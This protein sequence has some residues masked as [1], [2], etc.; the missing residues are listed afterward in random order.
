MMKH[1]IVWV[2]TAVFFLL[3][4]SGCMEERKETPTKG[5]VTVIASESVLPMVQAQEQK[6]EELYAEAHIELL[7]AQDRE[8]ISRLLSDSITII[9]TSRALNA[10][11]R[12]VHRRMNMTIAEYKIAYD[13]VAVV[14]NLENPIARLRTTQ[15]DSILRGIATTWKSVGGKSSGKIEVCLPSRNSGEFEVLSSK[16]T[17]GS[18]FATPVAVT[19]TSLEMITFVKN[20]PDAIGFVGLCWLNNQ[21]E[22]VQIVDL[23]DPHAPDS[24]GIAGQYFGAHT[25]YVY[26]RF[27]PLTHEIFIYSRADN[28]GVAAGFLTFITSGPGQKIV[29]NSGLVPATMPVRLVE[30]TNRPVQQ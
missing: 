13:G 12:N 2:S 23:A 7:S 29:L 21:K 9:V 25:A 1:N 14:V 17:H 16:V 19:Q 3:C 5:R 18:A 27:Y 30:T 8:S 10:E 22:K 24:L 11:E 15:L 26:Q 6:F 28:Y 4:L 20:H